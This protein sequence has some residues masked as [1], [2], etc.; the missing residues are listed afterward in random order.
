MNI[1]ICKGFLRK[2]RLLSIEKLGLAL[3]LKYKIFYWLIFKNKNKKQ[4]EHW[5]LQWKE[6]KPVRSVSNAANTE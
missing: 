4:P 6:E 3:Y 2:I 5:F 1:V